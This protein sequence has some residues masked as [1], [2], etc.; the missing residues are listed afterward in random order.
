[1]KRKQ[2][3]CLLLF[4]M[5]LFSDL[6]YAND[7][8]VLVWARQTL[9]STLTIDYTNMK[10]KFNKSKSNYMP[11]AWG[12]LKNFLG[13]KTALIQNDEL[14]LHPKALDAGS[15]IDAGTIS[16]VTY[17]RINQAISIPELTARLNFSLVVIKNTNPPFLIQ[18]LNVTN[19]DD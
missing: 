4:F 18:S 5:L 19:I 3:T 17:W 10:D 12:A 7:S 11:E 6:N 13:D 14:S 1:M 16:N 2:T 8:R 9:L 15:I